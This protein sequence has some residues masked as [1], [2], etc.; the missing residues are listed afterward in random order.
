MWRFLSAR[1]LIKRRL[2]IP[3]VKL[4]S[5]LNSI[6]LFITLIEQQYV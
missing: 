1:N 4:D 6:K 2:E 5:K 3:D